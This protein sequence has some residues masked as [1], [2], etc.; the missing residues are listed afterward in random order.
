MLALTTA[1][2]ADYA[3]IAKLAT[4]LRQV[5]P[6]A[7]IDVIVEYKQS[8]ANR[9]K[10]SRKYAGYAELDLQLPSWHGAARTV[11]ATE[12]AELASDPNVERISPDR[13]VF[14]AADYATE[15]IRATAARALGYD[16]RGVGIAIIDSGLRASSSLSRDARSRIVYRQSFIPADREHG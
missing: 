6:N 3:H 7:T 15:A 1:Y 14:R 4:D 12:L 2:G 5:D 8:P 13:E 9:G 11:K 16:G 10:Q